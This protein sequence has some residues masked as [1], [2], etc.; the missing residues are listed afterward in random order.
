MESDLLGLNLAVLD[1]HLVSAEDN[2]DGGSADTNDISV[3]VGDVLVGHTGSN[4]KHDDGAL[5]L[6]A[7]I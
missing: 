2:G 4:I 5:S 7:I 3:P 1:V 6:D